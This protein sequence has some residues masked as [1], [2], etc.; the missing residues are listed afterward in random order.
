MNR[1][2]R[3]RSGSRRAKMTHKNIKKWRNFMCWSAGCSL[4]SSEDFRLPLLVGRP[5][6][7][8]REK[9][10]WNFYLKSI[11]LF[12]AVICFSIVWSSKPWKPEPDPHWPTI[13]IR[14]RIKTNADP[15]DRSKQVETTFNHQLAAILKIGINHNLVV[16]LV[17]CFGSH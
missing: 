12:S 9:V 1:F 11:N 15:Q 6:W 2:A 10:N 14:I 8:P 3:S 16:H 13:R 5:S 4:S 7:R 17:G